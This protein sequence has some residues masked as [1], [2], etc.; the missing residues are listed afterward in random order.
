MTRCKL[1]LFTRGAW[2]SSQGP[3][4]GGCHPWHGRIQ[5]TPG[6]QHSASLPHPKYRLITSLSWP[7][8]TMTARVHETLAGITV[9][10]HQCYGCLLLWK[11]PLASHC[12]ALT[13]S[14]LIRGHIPVIP[15][16]GKLSQEACHG[17]ILGY[18]VSETRAAL[19]VAVLGC[20]LPY[21]PPAALGG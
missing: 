7:R 11:D 19:W 18:R 20:L 16:L 4:L 14:F 5:L 15:A 2:G 1:L 8:D 21:L 17:S 6:T 9:K 13:Q 3:H 12:P 10:S